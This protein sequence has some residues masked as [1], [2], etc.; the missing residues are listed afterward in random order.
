MEQEYHTE[1]ST[2]KKIKTEAKKL[3]EIHDMI[4]TNRA[5]VDDDICNGIK[6]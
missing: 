6:Y 4:S 2:K 5:V 3:T 1:I